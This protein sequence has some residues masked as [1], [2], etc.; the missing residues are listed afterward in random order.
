MAT[1]NIDD[2]AKLMLPVRFDAKL[3]NTYV[4]GGDIVIETIAQYLV[5]VR[6]QRVPGVPVMLMPKTGYESLGSYPIATYKAS[7]LR[8]DSP[9]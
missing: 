3:C 5:R 4:S 6:N 7:T 9:C 1:F 8:K 2:G